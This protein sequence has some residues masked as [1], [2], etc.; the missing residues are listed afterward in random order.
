MMKISDLCL[1][2]WQLRF[3]FEELII[4]VRNCHHC[5]RATLNHPIVWQMFQV[6]R[7]MEPSLCRLMPNVCLY[8]WNGEDKEIYWNSDRRWFAIP[9]MRQMIEVPIGL[10]AYGVPEEAIRKG[11][12]LTPFG[13]DD[14]AGQGGSV[15]K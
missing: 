3:T 11:Y 1:M 9:E 14:S 8:C 6:A 10:L 2:V 12:Q 15:Q 4:L 13:K 7:V 5:K